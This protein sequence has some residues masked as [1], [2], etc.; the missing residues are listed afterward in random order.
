[1][2]AFGYIFIIMA[3]SG[4]L[5]SLHVKEDKE[6]VA[7]FLYIGSSLGVVFSGD[8]LSLLIFWEIMAFASVFL[9][10]AHGTQAS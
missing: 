7:A 8:L 1:S 4:V 6:H 5:F 3:F 2:M 10:W 9:I